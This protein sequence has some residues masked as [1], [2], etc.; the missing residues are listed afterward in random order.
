MI[1]SGHNTGQVKEREKKFQ[2]KGGGILS[3]S[4]LG[5]INVSS[6]GVFWP[7]FP[8]RPRR[9]LSN[10]IMNRRQSSAGRGWILP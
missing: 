7:L 2:G 3:S 6:L 5:L 9:L 1:I 10:T 4:V 8:P